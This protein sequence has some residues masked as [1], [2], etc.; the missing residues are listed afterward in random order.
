MSTA[1]II[2]T[3]AIQRYVAAE[4]ITVSGVLS[5][6]ADVGVRVL[7]PAVSISEAYW[8]VKLDDSP[9]LDVFHTLPQL[10]VEPLQATDAM[11]VGNMARFMGSLGLANACML[12]RSMDIPLMTADPVPASK[13]LPAELIWEV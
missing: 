8:A 9:M 10:A 5:F 13:L 1:R 12:A 11:I 7:A 3:S 2:D 4:G 6:M